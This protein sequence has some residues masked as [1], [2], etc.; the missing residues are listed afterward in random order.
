MIYSANGYFKRTEFPAPVPLESVLNA[1]ETPLSLNEPVTCRTFV[2]FQSFHDF[3]LFSTCLNYSS[4]LCQ[5]ILIPAVAASVAESG[6]FPKLL[7][8]I[9]QALLYCRLAMTDIFFNVSRLFINAIVK[10][11]ICD[12]ICICQTRELTKRPH[13]KFMVEPLIYNICA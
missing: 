6:P 8:Q 10:P 1:D 3:C 9:Q 11:T 12:V 2:F 5:P 4:H 13:V 7:P